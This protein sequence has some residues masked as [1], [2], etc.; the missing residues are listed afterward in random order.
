[1]TNHQWTDAI[2][3]VPSSGGTYSY[4][5]D[6]TTSAYTV[7]ETNPTGYTLGGVRAGW[8]IYTAT[9]NATVSVSSHHSAE[10]TTIASFSLV[11]GV[12]TL[13][14]TDTNMTATANFSV[15]SGLTYYIRI[16]NI[17]SPAG[18]IIAVS[19]S[20]FP[21]P[22]ISLSGSITDVSSISASL[23]ITSPS[24]A[25]LLSIGF[26]PP[27]DAKLS[28]FGIQPDPYPPDPPLAVTVIAGDK[29][30]TISW[31][32]PPIGG[33]EIAYY[34][35]S[36][37]TATLTTASTSLTFPGLYNGQKY[38]FF[39]NSV[40]VKGLRS[41]KIPVVAVPTTIS[42]SVH[43][44]TKYDF[45]YHAWDIRVGSNR[46]GPEYAI[47]NNVKNRSLTYT[48]GA[49]PTFSFEISGLDPVANQIQELAS[50]AWV[51]CDGKL[52]YRGRI[53]SSSD[54]DDGTGLPTSTFESSGYEA[55]LDVRKL[56]TLPYH[57]TAIF[58]STWQPNGIIQWLISHAENQKGM[59]LGLTKGQWITLPP[60][61]TLYSTN[62]YTLDTITFTVEDGESI[63]ESVNTICKV[64]SPSIEFWVDSDLTY[65][66]AYTRGSDK[67]FILTPGMYSSFD[68]SFQSTDFANVIRATGRVP[69]KI[70]TSDSIA[71]VFPAYYESAGMG[72]PLN[73]T[74]SSATLVN[75]G[76]LTT[77]T[78]FP[79]AP[80]STDPIGGRQ[81]NIGDVR[82]YNQAGLDAYAKYEYGQ[83]SSIEDLYSY[84]VTMAPG[85]WHGKDSL[86]IGDTVTFYAARGR[87][88]VRKKMRVQSLTI[89][90]DDTGVETVSLMLNVAR[91]HALDLKRFRDAV[92]TL[93]KK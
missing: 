54:K 83:T 89:T 92:K 66:I 40:G 78:P 5:M 84:N 65:N 69:S 3:L 79:V 20:G 62:V 44:D 68:R 7:T 61:S 72:V 70:S 35:V 81:K 48:L 25:T 74:H 23:S 28:S 51:Y 71:T 18:E 4:S 64:I 2:V 31:L 90:V 21:P 49:A 42:P 53:N 29:Q 32:A 86:W 38:T 34:E 36:N 1:M 37:N 30:A 10:R 67:G 47:R 6:T 11:S 93:Q 41:T 82:V 46:V 16:A 24:I 56:H 19:G 45:H 22:P 33:S 73:A 39:V 76:A 59:R 13:L 80:F 9:A 77:N 14:S 91:N 88:N 43:L 17:D 52:I 50:D 12:W 60:L 87:V 8:F 75:D 57:A 58:G 15:T 27:G 55:L 63:Y 26:D 85:Q